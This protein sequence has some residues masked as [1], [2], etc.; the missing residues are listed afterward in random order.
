[1]LPDLPIADAVDSIAGNI[2]QR[3]EKPFDIDGNVL[4]TSVSIGIAVYPDDGRDFDTLLKKADTAMYQAKEAVGVILSID[5]FGTGYSS[6]SYLKR[7]AVDKLK[8]DQSFIR[9]MLN[10]PSDAAIVRAVIQMARSLGLKTI[11][12]G[13][14]DENMLEPL[15]MQQCD[16]VQGYYFARPMPADEFSL[17]LSGTREV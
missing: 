6:L 15:R 1:M 4:A 13:V 2:L 14:E 5:D 8:I 11:A 10:E 17:Y 12:E 7:F 9:N 3:L 16:E